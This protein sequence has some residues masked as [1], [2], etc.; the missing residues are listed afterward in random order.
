[1]NEPGSGVILEILPG[2]II[3]NSDAVIPVTPM[4]PSQATKMEPMYYHLHAIDLIIFITVK[5]IKIAFSVLF[6]LVG[7]ILTATVVTGN[8]ALVDHCDAVISITFLS[9]H[10]GVVIV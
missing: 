9:A 8:T 7:M 3:D 4:T 5:S 1:M 2:S 10:T 6:Q